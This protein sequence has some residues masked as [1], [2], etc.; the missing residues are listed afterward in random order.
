MKKYIVKW[1]A[2]EKEFED[3]EDA[4]NFAEETGETGINTYVYSEIDG[5]REEDF[6]YSCTWEI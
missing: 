1:K 3:L 5:I 6:F 2:D 4:V